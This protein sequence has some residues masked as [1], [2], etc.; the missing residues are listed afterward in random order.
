MTVYRPKGRRTYRYD[1]EWRGQ[2]YTGS[3]GQS[4]LRNAEEFERKERVRLERQSGDLSMRPGDTPRFQDWAETFFEHKLK[5][6]K[7]PDRMEREL[8]VVLEFFGARQPKRA[9]KLKGNRKPPPRRTVLVEAPYHDLRL[10]DPIDNPDWITKFEAWMLAR[11]T[12]GSSRNHYRSILS[13]M[14]KV[15]RLPQ[16]RRATGVRINPFDGIERDPPVRRRVTL[17]IEEIRRWILHAAPHV[18]LALAIGALAPTLRLGN[19]L[20][21]E[22]DRHIDRELQFITITDHKTDQANPEPRVIPIAA[23]LRE[24]LTA[25][26]ALAVADADRLGKRPAPWVVAYRRKRVAAIKKGLQAAAKRAD[27]N[28]GVSLG[29]ATFHTLRHTMATMLATLGVPDSH[30]K[31]VLGHSDIATTQI[32]THLRPMHL[33]GPL[34]QLS[35][36]VALGDVVGKSAGVASQSR[37]NAQANVSTSEQ[38]REAPKAPME[39]ENTGDVAAARR[40]S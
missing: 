16:Y 30:R 5:R 15:A 18:Q 8:R 23:Q 22:W 25:S 37:E 26:R 1:F 14:Y 29:G 39:P 4:T 28:Y 6:L 19:I 33:V 7:A 2:R 12:G 38:L 17:T 20:A 34:E 36:A 10:G 32:Y 11:K 13:G 3:T 31:E 21:L 24:I 35:A 27:I 9:P 40:A